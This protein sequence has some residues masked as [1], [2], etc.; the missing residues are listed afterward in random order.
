[1]APLLASE[2]CLIV[3]LLLPLNASRPA[4]VRLGLWIVSDAL[5]L[6]A[7]PLTPVPASDGLRIVS[8]AVPL[9]VSVPDAASD[10]LRILSAAVAVNVSVPL[11]AN[12]GLRIVSAPVPVIPAAAA[13]DGATHRCR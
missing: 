12:A 6:M 8:V 11:A 9:N 7:S 5:P 3:I 10:G 2:G 13:F 1:M 4:A